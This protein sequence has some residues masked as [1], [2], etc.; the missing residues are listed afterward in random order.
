M[1]FLKVGLF[2]FLNYEASFTQGKALFGLTVPGVQSL[3][4][5]SSNGP[6]FRAEFQER[7][8]HHMQK[9]SHWYVYMILLSVFLLESPGFN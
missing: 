6:F 3:G 5:K 2:C 1:A 4:A 8:R 9:T 7:L